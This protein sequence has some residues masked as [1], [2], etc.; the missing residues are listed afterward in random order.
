M[1]LSCRVMPTLASLRASRRQRVIDAVLVLAV[2]ALTGVSHRSAASNPWIDDRVLVAE[3]AWFQVA[4]PFF[5][6]AIPGAFST[7]GALASLVDPL[8][9]GSRTGDVRAL[10]ALLAAVAAGALYALLRSVGAPR[11]IALLMACA[12]ALGPILPVAHASSAAHALQMAAAATLLLL[13]HRRAQPGH[14][15]GLMSL[16]TIVGAVNHL[17]LVWFAAPLWAAVALRHSRPLLAVSVAVASLSAG[18]IAAALVMSMQ[19][20]RR[21]R[22]EPDRPEHWG[23]GR[24]IVDRSFPLRASGVRRWVRD[25]GCAGSRARAAAALRALVPPRD[26]R[27]RD[28]TNGRV[29][30]GRGH[31]P[32][33]VRTTNVG[34]GPERRLRGNHGGRRIPLRPHAGLDVAPRGP[35]R[36]R[37]CSRVC[38][39]PRGPWTMEPSGSRVDSGGAPP[40]RLHGFSRTSASVGGVD[41][42]A[43]CRRPSAVDERGRDRGRT[44]TAGHCGGRHVTSRRR[45]LCDVPRDCCDC[46]RVR[47]SGVPDSISNTRPRSRSC[48]RGVRGSGSPMP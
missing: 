6:T 8:I 35:R 40:R 26:R 25:G 33:A 39:A 22:L 7:T 38:S 27:R 15:L 36:W 9:V 43:P 4:A 46:C 41:R 19:I 44:A 34:T 47:T 48:N 18:A 45:A 42:R 37:A 5:H 17:A 16:V 31:H 24:R 20:D 30:G 3:P 28:T 11:A 2:I 14:L 23:T 29:D 21:G 32:G 10:A 1:S 13:A 12:I